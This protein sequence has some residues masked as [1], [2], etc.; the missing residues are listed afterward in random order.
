[1]EQLNERL[2]EQE[3]GLPAQLLI[4]ADDSVRSRAQGD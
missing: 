1:M 2:V 4:I 3:A